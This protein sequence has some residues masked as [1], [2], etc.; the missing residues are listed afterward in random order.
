MIELGSI[1]TLSD[2]NEY[3][4]V[5]KYNDNNIDYIYLVDINNNSNII[6]G[7]IENNEVVEVNDPDELE[8]MI[9]QVYVDTHNN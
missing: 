1:I 7:K 6:Y 5:D 2:D 8:K 4:V 9:K 3:T